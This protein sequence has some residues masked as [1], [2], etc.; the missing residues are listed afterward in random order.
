MIPIISFSNII[1]QKYFFPNS[2]C[3]FTQKYPALI[4]GRGSISCYHLYSQTTH[5][6]CL[7]KYSIHYSCDTPVRL[8]GTTPSQS[9]PSSTGSSKMYSYLFPLTPLITRQFSVSY[10]QILLLLFYAFISYLKLLIII[11]FH[12]YFVNS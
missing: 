12:F 9:T 6:V 1:N 3:S 5:I 10:Q 8:T 2:F 4:K 11:S 7:D